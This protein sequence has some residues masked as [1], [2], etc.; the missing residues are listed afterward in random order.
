M[1]K[2]GFVYIWYDRHR[3]MYYIGSHWGRLD[4]GYVCSSTRMRKAYRRRPND[5]KRRI[6]EIVETN[7]GDLLDAEHL[8]LSKI[9]DVELGTKYYNLSKHR[10]G[11]WSHDEKTRNTVIEKIKKI[12]SGRERKQKR[13]LAMLGDK[14]PMKK[15]EVVEKVIRKNLGKVPWNK[16]LILGPNA[17][18]SKA[19][20]GRVSTKKGIP[21][22][23]ITRETFGKNWEIIT[24]DNEIVV[25]KNLNL[26]CQENGLT[27]ANMAKV[28]RGERNHHRGYKCR[29]L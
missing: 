27:V 20:K 13:R 4:D 28:S 2:Y 29:Q 22:A 8:W 1:E 15:K 9:S 21:V 17:N 24:P 26:Y 19:L 16:G 7:R 23:K 12:E 6:L 11:H 25:V 18:L 5:F 14:N 3:K 10:F